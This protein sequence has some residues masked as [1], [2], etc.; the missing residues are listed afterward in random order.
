MADDVLELADKLWRGDID[1][2]EIH[3][4]GGYMGGRGRGRRRG[5]LRPRLS[6]TC[7][8]S[9]PTTGSCSSTRARAFVAGA[10]HEAV[11]GVVGAPAQHGHLLPRPHRPRLRRGRVGGGV[12]RRRVGPRPVV[13]AHDAVP[14]RFDRYIVTAG[15]NEII[16]QRQFGVP[17]FRWPTE[18]RYPDRTY[19]QRLELDVGGVGLRAAP[20]PGRDRR[21]H[22]DLGGRHA[23]AVL[24]RPLHLGVAQRRQPPEG[25]ALPARVGRRPAGDDRRSSPRS[26]SRATAS[27]S[28]APSGSARPSPTPPTCS[29]R[30]STRPS[31]S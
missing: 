14:A 16:N 29:T 3:P 18:Y 2:V 31:P 28:S 21:P 17:G 13:V 10:V 8:P 4:V 9:P 25:A 1:I 24:R 30:S 22:L 26:C 20:R 7:R 12:G 23:G 6:P 19:A 5:R 11:A 27:P 15:Y